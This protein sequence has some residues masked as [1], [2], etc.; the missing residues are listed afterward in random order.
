MYINQQ[1]IIF[2]RNGMTLV[3][4]VS[5]TAK[6]LPIDDVD[7]AILENLCV[8]EN[9]TESLDTYIAQIA[10][11]PIIA[12]GFPSISKENLNQRIQHYIDAGILLK[13]PT[14]DPAVI[15]PKRINELNFD[16]HKVDLEDELRMGTH[17]AISLHANGMCFWSSTAQEFVKINALEAV[18]VTA[19]SSGRTVASLF[20]DKAYLGFDDTS[21]LKTVGQLKA[22]GVLA[23]KKETLEN[24]KVDAIPFYAQTLQTD[25][26]TDWKTLKPN[27]RTPVY[28]VP[29]MEN[30][31]PL[32]LGVLYSA[33]VKHN[34]GA[35]LDHYQFIPL[36]FLSPKDFI[37]GPYRKFGV[38]IW[39]FSNYMWS[40]EVNMQVSDAVKQHN[41]DNFTIHGGPS[42]PDYEQA[43]ID[44]MN[45]N[46]SVDIAVHGE[47]EITITEV[48][49][50]L[51]PNKN[52]G[53]T[54]NAHKMASVT[55]LTYRDP[56]TKSLMRTN[57]RERMK[58]PDA[59][60]SPY[61][62]GLFDGYGGRV[63]AAIIETNRGC[64]YGCTFCDWGS[65]TN[66]KI[67]K[68]DMERVEQEITWI[69]KNN[70]R[71]LWIA[72]ANFGL[73]DR[74][75]E[76]SR[77]IIE[78][79]QKYGY[80][81]EIVVN[82]TKNATWRLV[83]IIKIFSE[84]GIIGQGII[85]IQ[86]T[87]EKTLEVIDRKNIRTQRYDE[88]AKAFT[89]LNLPLSTDL[90]IGLP[91]MTVDSFLNDLQRYIDMDI[92]VKAYP[93]QLLPNSPMAA[94]DY[95]QKYKIQADEHGYLTSTFS[96]SEAELQTMLSLNEIYMMAEGYGLLRYVV[97][98]LQWE[99]DIAAK[100]FFLDILNNVRA[101]PD[102]YP[103]VTWAV[104]FFN[105]D[106][107]MP[108]GWWPFFE[109]VKLFISD[110]YHIDIDSGLDTVLKVNA[111]AMP[112]DALTYPISIEV[113]HDFASYFIEQKAAQNTLSKL[114]TYGSSN[115]QFA[116]PNKLATI[117]LE[118][119]QYD[120]HQY[121]YEL[122][123]AVARP[124]SI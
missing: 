56:L 27:G 101:H 43:C 20:S 14:G 94:P 117:D 90:M 46:A 13:Q 67:R 24:K 33:L 86:T 104:R 44:F 32:A 68:F 22:L 89:D 42:T 41:P 103:L 85:S 30:H 26:G 29:H 108:S 40:I 5:G 107:S 38:G 84:G 49:E 63:E 25:L 48:F 45:E 99:H 119:A 36:N 57:A 124:K 69:G 109:Q 80:P 97:R 112:D 54:I 65:A 114:A 88:L 113:E 21:I 35:L 93:T 16:V 66:Q 105:K 34:D 55:G 2:S 98:F 59:V 53:V 111:A 74:D 39:L 60:P 76:I 95:L 70:V 100:R 73:Y 121:F 75:I 61:L 120:S 37:F 91:G 72:D 62:S 9:I 81:Q 116:D 7:L 78:T 19:F 106:K 58:Q 15:T 1:K 47:G 77:Y 115:M 11:H 102:R 64:P 110:T 96:Y 92:S 6:S 18:L 87:D 123:S 8:S 122:H 82:Y 52:A 51:S 71:V 31:L 28:F 79:K 50:S 17:A 12:N 118:A 3:S 83:E 23:D 4:S 10:R